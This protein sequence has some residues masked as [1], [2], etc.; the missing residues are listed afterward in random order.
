MAL[1]AEVQEEFPDLIVRQRGDSIVAEGT[2]SLFENGKAADQ[3]AVRVELPP[4]SPKGYPTLFEIG[5]RIPAIPDRHVNEGAMSCCVLAVDELLFKY[6]NG[7]S[8]LD[9]LRGPVR[10]FFISQS[11][12]ESNQDWPFGARSHGLEGRVEF[13]A[14]QVGCHDVAV[15]LRVLFLI[16]AATASSK[17]DCPC[18]S[19]RRLRRCH[20]EVI[21]HL[22]ER[23]PRRV[24]RDLLAGIEKG[25]EWTSKPKGPTDANRLKRR[26]WWPTS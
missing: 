7:C 19:R 20:R 3:F 9:F 12:F 6:P 1:E 23:I 22:R 17:A 5:G 2:F 21:R 4:E 10:D 11:Y 25:I 26:R 24:A 16:A 15:G 14:E 18:G 13:Y 8:L